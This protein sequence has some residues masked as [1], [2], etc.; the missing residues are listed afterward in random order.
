MFGVVELD[1]V[2]SLACNDSFQLSGQ[3]PNWRFAF[4][5][6]EALVHGRDTLCEAMAQGPAPAA[7]LGKLGT[8]PDSFGSPHARGRFFESHHVPSGP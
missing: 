7:S 6:I 2:G 5:A 3:G 8:Y 1:A 4:L